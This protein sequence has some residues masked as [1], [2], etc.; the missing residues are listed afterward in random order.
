MADFPQVPFMAFV[1][2]TLGRAASDAASF[3][4]WDLKTAG[5][6]IALG[7]VGLAIFLRVRG[8]AAAQEHVANSWL[9]T[10]IPTILFLACLVVGTF[11][12]LRTLSTSRNTPRPCGRFRRPTAREI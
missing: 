3:F 12:A 6:L 11:F 5:T 9:L 4:G 7:A 10:G 1:L 8:L 2:R